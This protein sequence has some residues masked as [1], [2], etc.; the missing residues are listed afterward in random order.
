[1][2]EAKFLPINDVIYKSSNQWLNRPNRG[3]D[4]NIDTAHMR[5]VHR[6]EDW[7]HYAEEEAAHEQKDYQMN[8]VK[9]S[10][11]NDIVTVPYEIYIWVTGVFYAH[12]CLENHTSDPRTET[13]IKDAGQAIDVLGDDTY[14]GVGGEEADCR[15]NSGRNPFWLVIDFFLLIIIL[16]LLIHEIKLELFV[17]VATMEAM[18]VYT[19]PQFTNLTSSDLARSGLLLFQS[20]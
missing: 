6:H 20:T 9:F 15:T 16:Q 3:Y 17:T 14:D 8:D 2:V 11:N 19:L 7:A 5:E 1:M 4:T 10:I 18:T 13:Q 12:D